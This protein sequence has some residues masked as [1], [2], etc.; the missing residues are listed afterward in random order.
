MKYEI[1]V[2]KK[3]DGTCLEISDG[4]GYIYVYH[5]RE[6]ISG[7]FELYRNI[8]WADDKKIKEGCVSYYMSGGSNIKYSIKYIGVIC[9]IREVKIQ[10]K[11]MIIS[12]LN[13]SNYTYN[14]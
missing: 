9:S 10:I 6:N 7:L 4:D 11:T 13:I 5:I 2:K 14:V 3:W 8:Q 1:K 12:D